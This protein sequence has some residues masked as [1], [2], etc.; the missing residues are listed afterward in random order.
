MPSHREAVALAER[1]HAEGIPLIRRW[2][3]LILGANNEDRARELAQTL[4]L[5]APPTASVRIKQARFS[6]YGP[7]DAAE[8]FPQL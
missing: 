6:H 1:L 5:E 2:R 3:Y 7:A 4:E 8:V